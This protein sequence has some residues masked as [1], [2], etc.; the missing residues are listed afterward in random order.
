MKKSFSSMNKEEFEIVMKDEYAAR[1][2]RS[3]INALRDDMSNA[4]DAIEKLVVQMGKDR[5]ALK[6]LLEEV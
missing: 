4:R 5:L 6:R 2:K 3:E 1:A